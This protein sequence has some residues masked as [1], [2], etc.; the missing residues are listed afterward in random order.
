[1]SDLNT[2]IAEQIAARPIEAR[3]V[4]RI[5]NALKRA[6]EPVVAVWDG[7]ERTEVKSLDDLNTAV[8]NLDE[9]ELYTKSGG[10]IYI[11]MGQDWEMI[12]DHSL[13]L[14]DLDGNGPLV[15]V[16]EWISQNW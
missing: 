2:Y 15:P 16:N 6:G 11:V 9:A 14:D 12:A 1:M 8:F 3:I 13:S 5:Y 7:E 4:K 10:T